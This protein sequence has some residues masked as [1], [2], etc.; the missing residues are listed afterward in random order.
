MNGRPYLQASPRASSRLA[1]LLFSSILGIVKKK[2]QRKKAKINESST[3]LDK[4]WTELSSFIWRNTNN[5]TREIIMHQ[6][7]M[8]SKVHLEGERGRG[9]RERGVMRGRERDG[10][11]ETYGILVWLASVM[12]FSWDRWKRFSKFCILFPSFKSI[13]KI[14][15]R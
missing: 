10:E 6:W 12:K 7:L 14:V 3:A 15:S 9:K 13:V 11:V 8:D 2:I 4:V 1:F 5:D